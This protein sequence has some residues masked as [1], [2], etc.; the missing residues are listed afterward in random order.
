M[1]HTCLGLFILKHKLEGQ[2]HQLGKLYEKS[3]MKEWEIEP[4]FNNQLT[5]SN[6]HSLPNQKANRKFIKNMIT[7]SLYFVFRSSIE[8][9]QTK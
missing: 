4:G 8:S 1:F 3:K 2:F 9:S 5:I 7:K 6:S